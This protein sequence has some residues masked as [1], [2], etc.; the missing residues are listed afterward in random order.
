MGMTRAWGSEEMEEEEKCEKM[1]N[2]FRD[3]VD[4]WVGP[5]LIWDT[6]NDWIEDYNSHSGKSTVGNLSTIASDSLEMP[7]IT[8]SSTF[9]C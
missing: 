4:E 2:S 5:D 6:V 8:T 3:L 9:G 1:K 7:T